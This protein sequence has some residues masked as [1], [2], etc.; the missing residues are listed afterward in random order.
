MF[1]FSQPAS[2]NIQRETEQSTNHPNKNPSKLFC[3]YQ[4]TDSKVCMERQKTQNSQHSI[5]G[6]Q[7]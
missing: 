1:Y 3:G 6:E 4:P 7:S 2:C 5:E